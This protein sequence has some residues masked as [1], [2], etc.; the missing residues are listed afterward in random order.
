VSKKIKNSGDIFRLIPDIHK[1]VTSSHLLGPRNLFIKS[2]LKYFDEMPLRDDT[3]GVVYIVRNPLDVIA[4]AIDYLPLRDSNAYSEA[5]EEQRQQARQSLLNEFLE[6]GG[7][8]RWTRQGMGAWPEHV[9]SW[10]RKDLP[11][12]R[13]TF[14]YEDLK[15]QPVEC[16]AKLCRFLSINRSADQIEAALSASSFENMRAMEEK[17]IAEGQPGLFAAENPKSTFSLGLRF[18]NKG[19]SGSFQEA[20]TDAQIEMAKERFGPIMR[21]FGYL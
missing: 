14:K 11:F 12:P 7:P 16:V 1:G 10:H 3:I 4:S 21:Q 18:M 2:H 5:N 17:E 9:A 13:I 20:L 8:E 19:T 15:A 6:K